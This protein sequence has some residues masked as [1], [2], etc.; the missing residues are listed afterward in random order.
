MNY[1]EAKF[2]RERKDRPSDWLIVQV[3][4]SFRLLQVAQF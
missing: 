3:G 1:Y 4:R 2:A